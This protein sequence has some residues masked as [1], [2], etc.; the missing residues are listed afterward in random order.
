MMHILLHA[1]VC[2]IFRQY[3]GTDL[4]KLKNTEVRDYWHIFKGT[5]TSSISKLN[6]VLKSRADMEL[7]VNTLRKKMSRRLV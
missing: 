6:V 7:T 5:L 2:C 4:L 3:K 1:A